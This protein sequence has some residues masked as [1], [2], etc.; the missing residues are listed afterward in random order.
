[1]GLEVLLER[2]ELAEKERRRRPWIIET[3]G[4]RV[5]Q[6]RS[7]NGNEIPLDVLRYAVLSIVVLVD[8]GAS[9]LSPFITDKLRFLGYIADPRGGGLARGVG[10]LVSTVKGILPRHSNVE[11]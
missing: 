4:S 7:A 9:Q 3:A 1:L 8:K 2:A 5:G 11:D 6:L 10:I